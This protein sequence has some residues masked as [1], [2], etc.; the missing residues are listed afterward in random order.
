MVSFWLELKEYRDYWFV[1][2]A[3][4]RFWKIHF[5]IVFT[6]PTS[7]GG[8]TFVPCFWC[9][10]VRNDAFDWGYFRWYGKFQAGIGRLLGRIDC[11]GSKNGFAENPLS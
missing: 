4:M 10:F 5:P 8:C 11:F 7:G 6:N 1:L 2:E 3:G 9:V